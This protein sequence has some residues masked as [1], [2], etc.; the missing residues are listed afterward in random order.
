MNHETQYD[1]INNANS[2]I[3]TT[4]TKNYNT[5]RISN[6]RTII[7]WLING[8][9]IR[10]FI[11]SNDKMDTQ[12]QMDE[13]NGV[14][15]S[16]N[17][18]HYI[19]KAGF[20]K[21]NDNQ[22]C[23]VIILSHFAYVYYLS[24]DL[25]SHYISNHT[26]F[27]SKFNSIDIKQS[28]TTIN[29]SL[30]VNFP[31]Q[32]EKA[33]WYSNGIILQTINN[34][35]LQYKWITFTDPMSP[36]GNIQINSNFITD[37]LFNIH[38]YKN[39]SP[40]DML[41]FPKTNKSTITVI[42]DKISS[43]LLFF[44]TKIRNSSNN[45]NSIHSTTTT[46]TTTTNQPKRK[47]SFLKKRDDLLTDYNKNSSNINQ[48]TTSTNNTVNK[49]NISATIDRMSSGIN[50]TPP[51]T[52]DI[53][54]NI[55]NINPHPES[56]LI[57][58]II[59]D[60]SNQSHFQ[61]KD[62]TLV[63][64]STVVIPSIIDPNSMSLKCLSLFSNE[65]EMIV[66]F[67]P[68]TKYIKIWCINMIPDI[69]NS[70]QF[71]IYGNSPPNLITLEELPTD[72]L[73]TKNII[74]NI[75]PLNINIDENM[76][77]PDII[78]S[79][80][81]IEFDNKN[82]VFY[83]PFLKVYSPLFS[84]MNRHTN[85]DMLFPKSSFMKSIFNA[86][87]FIIKQSMYYRIF[88]LWQYLYSNQDN[89]IDTTTKEFQTFAD[90]LLALI[91]SKVDDSKISVHIKSLSLFQALV[92]NQDIQ[93][94][95]PKIIM[96]L[97][98]FS[99]E[100][101]L[102]ILNKNKK[103]KLD[104]FLSN[105]VQLMNWPRPWKLYYK[106]R[107][108][109]DKFLYIKDKFPFAH[110]LDEP[111]SIMRSLYSIIENSQIPVTP[112]IS[113]ARL[114]E[115]NDSSIDLLVTPRSFKLLR[116]YE[117]IHSSKFNNTYNDGQQPSIMAILKKL[118]IDKLEIES[119]PLAIHSVIKNLL[120]EYERNVTCPSI[121]MD[122]SLIER[123]DIARSISLVSRKRYTGNTRS[124]LK[125]QHDVTGTSINKYGTR[126]GAESIFASTTHKPPNYNKYSVTF[127][128]NTNFTNITKPNDIY[129]VVSKIIKRT[130]SSE[131]LRR[132]KP[133]PQTFTRSDNRL[134]FT[135]D[136]RFENVETILN[137][138]NI[139]KFNLITTESDYSK[140]LL[141]KKLYTRFVALRTLASGLG[142]AALY[143][144]TEQPLTSQRCVIPELN[145]TTAFPDNTKMV[146]QVELPVIDPNNNDI[147]DEELQIPKI[148]SDLAQWGNFHN[149]ISYALMISPKT[150]GINGSW[151]TL[152][153]P[154]NQLNA[155]HGGFLLGMGL[156]GHLKNLEEWH[157]YNYLSPKETFTSIGL[158]LGM[159]ASCRGTKN[160]KLVKVLAVHVVAL[161]PKGSNDLNINLKVQNAGL[162][163]MG[164]LY[165]GHKDKKLN[166]SLISE[167]KSF[168]KVGEEFIVD[169]SYRIAVGIALGLNNLNTN[170]NDLSNQYDSDTD[171][172]DSGLHDILSF[173][174][175]PY[176]SSKTTEYSYKNTAIFNSTNKFD[177][178]T[179]NINPNSTLVHELLKLLNQH[180]DK[181]PF[182]IPENSQ[183]GALIAL[184]CMFLKTEE[185][186]ISSQIRLSIPTRATTIYC[187]PELY[188]YREFCYFMINW[189]VIYG[190][191]EFIM[192]DIN[193]SA[194]NS[195]DLPPIY[196][197]MAGR[198]LAI[199]IKYVS[200]GEIQV[201]NCL[202]SLLDRYLPFYQYINAKMSV[203]TISKINAITALVN[204]LLISVS[205][206]MCSTGDLM[207]FRRV[208]YLHEVITGRYSDIYSFNKDK[209]TK[210]TSKDERKQETGNRSHNNADV[211]EFETAGVANDIDPINN[212]SRNSDKEKDLDSHYGKYMVTS[213]CLGFLFL[214]CGQYA[215]NTSTVESTAYVIISVLPFLKNP[216]NLQE[217]KYFWSMSVEPRCLF[218]KDVLTEKVI[219]GASVEITMKKSC[220]TDPM[221][222]KSYTPCLLPDI[223]K[224]KKLKIEMN[225]YYPLEFVFDK[226]FP[227][228]D[229]FQSGTTIYMQPK[230]ENNEKICTPEDI[231]F[232][233]K[234][235]L[236]DTDERKHR[237]FNFAS[238]LY[239]TLDISDLTLFELKSLL[240]DSD[241]NNS[242]SDKYDIE[243]LCTDKLSGNITNFQLELW[244]T[245]QNNL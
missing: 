161:L 21:F 228:I 43:Q 83:N 240:N 71:K 34:N 210:S 204:A 56:G 157:V 75:M 205:L 123:P 20:I 39:I 41:H 105:A 6:D 141:K 171:S 167:L 18:N 42:F 54:K 27:S 168:V 7:E 31:F 130:L 243:M 133:I 70:I 98:L 224:I 231:K 119:Y 183:I 92:C 67:D 12:I 191:I 200:T 144:A 135:N 96:G 59:N 100:L 195:C 33:F 85:V 50:L 199:G 108:S 1:K 11:F 28:S 214:G 215:L 26:K 89:S 147:S 217:L 162:V 189:S 118:N 126:I 86:L 182:W 209:K 49:R 9:C 174:G 236:N 146:A 82:F 143:Y 51:H 196:Y 72:D 35:N 69:I 48:S 172:D 106:S 208:K 104:K 32:I 84:K 149:G 90:I 218:V 122:L 15:S 80:L 223:R 136:K 23:F 124:D 74:S 137:G 114:I 170:S 192:H 180:Y 244:K 186:D 159:S 185:V 177:P 64:I 97:H 5:I 91:Y 230:G 140:L 134:F 13:H 109:I 36:F 235:R 115:T 125:R 164:L 44:Y 176:T 121:G 158:L 156:N 129:N 201:R 132:T 188:M 46:T 187:K 216:Y 207:V 55:T 153:K 77:S 116:L 63:Q 165:L 37:N 102:N 150:K 197:I 181:E 226:E 107:S 87:S 166:Q 175:E 2:T 62:I 206:V 93:V 99:E 3:T 232:G 142:R 202:L 139:H 173:N 151:I 120:N 241:I 193:L 237:E 53:S 88:Y 60:I 73:F 94:I 160:F 112:F 95:L 148:S 227:A 229:F 131:T 198:I 16:K 225:H 4:T 101:Y 203:A 10:K 29:D 117:F 22:E 30:L 47:V 68:M 79:T 113:F 58:D 65:R 38:Y 45:I 81:I 219:D 145:L 128:Q 211:P 179:D 213:M 245:T 154:R 127:K 40:A 19:I 238:T 163:G 61:T 233:L 194:T 17:N 220:S 52:T 24:E 57:G 103:I 66:V 111:P 155:T 138:S 78:N 169:E 222:K 212:Q 234:R 14:F 242:E 110:P 190:S 178:K 152:N 25:S 239:K 221:I 184:I 76:R 8:K